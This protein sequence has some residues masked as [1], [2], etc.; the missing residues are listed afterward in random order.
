M[1]RIQTCA[2]IHL[3]DAFYDPAICKQNTRTLQLRSSIWKIIFNDQV[4]RV[5]GGYVFTAVALIIFYD[6]TS[7]SIM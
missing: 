3:F 7:E 5:G 6:Y 1:K 2:N 4:N